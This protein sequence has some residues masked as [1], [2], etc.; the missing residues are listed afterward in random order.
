MLILKGAK[1]LTDSRKAKL[2][3]ELASL[4]SRIGDIDAQFVYFVETNLPISDDQTQERLQSIL[5]ASAVS[6][7]ALDSNQVL[8]VPRLGTISPWSS[9]ATEILQRCGFSGTVSYTH[10]TL[11]TIYSV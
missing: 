9:K 2:L 11:P 1:A 3:N 4:K 7:K 8:V 6:L 5:Q 10:L